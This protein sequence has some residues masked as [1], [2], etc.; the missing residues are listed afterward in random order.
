[1][2]DIVKSDYINNKRREYSLYVLQS[3]AIP[4]LADGLKVSARRV[5]WT[6][7]DGKKYKSATLAGLTMPL[8]PHAPP[9]GTVNALAAPFINNKPLLDGYGA[10]GTLLNPN[11][12][13]AA[14]YT[15]VKLSEFAKKVVFVDIDIIPMIDNYDSTQLEPK[16]FLPLVPLVLINPVEGIAIGYSTSIY[17][18]RFSDVVKN[19]IRYL[20]GEQLEPM[21]PTIDPLKMRAKRTEKGFVF[22]GVFERRGKNKVIVT[23]LPY[24]LSHSK[25][26]FDEMSILNTLIDKGVIQ[27]YVDRSKDEVNIEITLSENSDKYTDDQIIELLKLRTNVTENICVLDF[28]HDGVLILSDLD[29]IRLFTDWRLKWYKVRYAKKIEDVT[30]EME[31]VGDVILAIQNDAGAVAK[32][33]ANRQ[34][35]IEWLK[36]IKIKNTDYIAS[37]PTYKYT[38]EEY[39]KAIKEFKSLQKTLKVYKKIHDTPELQR[40]IY[41]DEL[42]NILNQFKEE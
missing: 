18:R 25:Y 4:S 2:V 30:K 3:R 9:E 23:K 35:F 1:M 16:H 24:G 40:K 27:K 11:A 28:D 5:L 33:V 39:E 34:Q 14:R 7:R 19:Q 17:P 12:F 26:A 29:V 6:A 32:K 10:F 22:E 31:K 36:S 42:E 13:G 38:K 21:V 8:H 37:L 41:I 15:S 20:K